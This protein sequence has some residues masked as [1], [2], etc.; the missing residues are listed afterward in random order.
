MAK[1]NRSD[2][3][4]TYS[5]STDGG[6]NPKLRGEP[7]SNLLDRT[8]GYEVLY[9]INKIC[10]TRNFTDNKYACNWMEDI[11]KNLPPRTHTQV[12]VKKIIIDK[13]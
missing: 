1:F 10:E 7:D 11:I 4:H 9:L 8:E 6:D 3:K 5:W 13:L 2:L 12:E